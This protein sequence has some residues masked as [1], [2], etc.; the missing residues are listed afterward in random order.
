MSKNLSGSIFS[1][2]SLI[3]STSRSVFLYIYYIS[4]IY[5]SFNSGKVNNKSLIKSFKI[6]NKFNLSFF[7]TSSFYFIFII[8]IFH[9]NDI[10]LYFLNG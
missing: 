3:D 7:S 8:I 4:F 5:I 1:Q 6:F 2:Y 10:L 9:N